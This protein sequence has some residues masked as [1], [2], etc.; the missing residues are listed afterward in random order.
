MMTFDNHD[1]RIRYI[2]LILER[3]DLQNIAHYDLP[4]GYRFVFYRPGDRDAWIDIEISAKELTSFEQGVEVWQ[5]Y[6][7]HVEHL[8]S[9]RMLFIE[10]E[11]GEKVATATA[12]WDETLAPDL[13]QLHWVAVK[14][15]H[16]GRALAR[17][18]ISRTL[19]LMAEHGHT[20]AVL[21]T[22]TTTWVACRL[23]LEFGFHPEK[24]NAV[25]NEMGWRII[26]TLTKHSALASF[27]PVE[28]SEICN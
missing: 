6:Y 3:D 19:E 26:R 2:D 20:R 13:C 22:Q 9:R 10:D 17:P 12:F 21:H 11:R 7:G 18:L 24:E 15:T 27:E 25:Q 14:R 8:L 23:Y 16:Q 1:S 5:R 28:E 4:E